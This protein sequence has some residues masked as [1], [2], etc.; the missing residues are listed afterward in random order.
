M[1]YKKIGEG[2]WEIPKEGGMLVPARIYGTEKIV[3]AIESDAITQI[4]NVAYLPG[5]QKYSIAL[6]DAHLGYGF[7]IGG[8]AG[9]DYETGVVSPGGVG[10]DINCIK[11]DTKILHEFGYYKSIKE[12]EKDWSNNRIKCLNPTKKVKDT[13]INAFMKLKTRNKVFKVKT[14]SGL[15]IIATEEHPFLTE[16]GMIEL[17]KIN[18][19][20]ISVYPF[21]G[22]KYEEPPDEILISKQD[23]RKNY[24]K[25]GLG[26]EQITKKLK[27]LDLLPL[28]MNNPKLPY[29]IKLMGYITG[30][31]T[32][33]FLKS[34]RSQIFFY[35][36]E[37]DL[38]EIRKDI[39]RIGFKASKTYFRNRNHKIET[40]Y[41]V[42]K[43]NRTEK[44]IKS[45]SNALG[46][47]LSLLG[48][49]SG[50]KTWK[51]FEVP[52]WLLKSPEW[53]KRLYL[54]SY[55]GAELSSP[56]TIT[57]HDFNFYSPLLSINKK[58]EK[59]ENAR[60]FLK[61]IKEMLL[62]SGIESNLIK[63]REEF[64]NKKGEISIRLRLMI[65]GT[66]K[67]LIKFWGK[68]GFEYNQKKQFLA[69]VAVHY[70]KSKQKITEERN[71]AEKEATKLH[72]KGAGAKKIYKILKEKYKNIN[73]RFIE[74]SIYEKRKTSARIAF[75]SYTFEE[76]NKEKT[77]GLG[78]TGQVW[79]KI[80]SKEEVPFD[81][82]VY[83]FNVEDKNHNFIANNFVVSNCGVRLIKTN[84]E[85]KD[86]KPKMN[87]L[88]NRLFE[89]VPSGLGSKGQF[90]ANRNQLNEVMQEGA[91]WAVREGFGWKKDLEAM[92]E[93]GSIELADSSK[94]SEKAISRGLPQLGSLGSG[95][96]FLEIQIVQE[97][98]D[99]KTAGKFGLKK[100]Q[101]VLMAH[102]GS[103]G[104]GHQ[105]ASDY[106]DLMVSAMNKYNIKVPD[107]QLCCA[108]V[109]STEGQNYL[110]AM[111]CAVN[112]AFANR[113]MI[114]HW[115]RQGFSKIMGRSPEE[116]G[117]ELLY[118]VAHNIAKIEEHQ[119][120]GKK[121]KLL[122]HRKGATRAFPAGR[123]ENPKIYSETGH[124]AIIPGSMGT[125][126]WVVIGTEKGLEETFGSIAHGAGRVMSRNAAIAKKKGIDVQKELLQQGKI[127]KAAS[128]GT[129]AE[130]A[131]YAY[132]DVDEVV[133][134]LELSGIAKK[135]ARMT[136][137]GVVKG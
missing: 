128:L 1:E 100:G 73:L 54:A 56:K 31:G 48:T 124:P 84:L 90:K 45:C 34:G 96:H 104:L 11:G 98:F 66:P 115:T 106:L 123:K 46:L 38:D 127:V 103:R 36:E 126:S 131:P 42:V 72:K 22:I 65:R 15:E 113:Q 122:V 25:K 108:P 92:E 53:M 78:Q 70:L 49:P 120:E 6:P 35:G 57:D 51:D 89:E 129:L 117:M 79:D 30:D 75:S 112:Y 111:Y 110:G 88:V 19:E 82:L 121:K 130:E 43:F 44:S 32:L 20:R 80:I 68:T 119:I 52:K 101:I 93:N 132:K 29:L 86:V 71:K 69:N 107:R 99:E 8:V 50:N 77:N 136:P 133:K 33:T 135:V 27:E 14:E 85:L 91:K 10:Y 37:E 109:T 134:S 58:K 59:V 28:R 118:D 4:K 63:E 125:A 94:V 62:E 7:C 5:I 21:E 12:F 16:K 102:S 95:N 64:K 114:M 105:I 24:C 47:I 3:K 18:E 116:M 40:S 13:K 23:L 81:E 97:V 83:D 39:E 26:F 74:R 137:L 17:K 67:N 41:G 61:Q 87:E 76:F 60:K 9:I 55:F 2:I